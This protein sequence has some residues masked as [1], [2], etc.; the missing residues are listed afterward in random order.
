MGGG[1]GVRA[2]VRLLIVTA[3]LVA[4]T[5]GP[6]AAD[7][8]SDAYID[9][10]DGPTVEVTDDE[11]TQGGDGA[12]QD[13]TCI[14]RVGVEDDFAMGVFDVDGSRLYSETGR[15]LERVC[16]GSIQPINGMGIVPEGGA[17]DPVA[18]AAQARASIPIAAPGIE[19][20]PDADQQTYAQ[21]TTWLWIDGSWW[22]P[23]TATASAGR[24]SATVTASPASASWST[25]DG[26]NVTCRGPGVEWRRGLDDDDTY[27]SHV[28]R[29]SSAGR[30]GDA[31]R[32]TVTVSFEV[33]WSS[34]VGPGG[35][36]EGLDRTSSRS[37]RVGEIQAVETE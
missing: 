15:W 29:Q 25:G 27:C 20:S 12:S 3:A 19:T 9:P 5:A 36:L 37:L 18:L 22:T 30:E 26:G 2:V 17:V 32:L 24:V 4:L 14:W 23:Y 6:A 21:V 13:E 28:Y 1:R 8:E 10:V 34:N 16:D 7:G 31:Y 11:T 33:T 35:A